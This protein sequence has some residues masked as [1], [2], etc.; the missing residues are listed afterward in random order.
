MPF[1]FCSMVYRLSLFRCIASCLLVQSSLRGFWRR[2]C[3]LLVSC[4]VIVKLSTGWTRFSEGSWGVLLFVVGVGVCWAHGGRFRGAS[5]LNLIGTAFGL[6]VGLFIRLPN[7][8]PW[9]DLSLPHALP[10]Q[11]RKIHQ[12]RKSNPKRL[13]KCIFSTLFS[14]TS[15]RPPIHFRLYYSFPRE[16][17]RY[18]APPD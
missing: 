6:M 2:F 18:V 14:R 7:C 9:A 15:V 17:G 5:A 12:C 8:L 11:I 13:V 16:I 1:F 4:G 10:G 3:G